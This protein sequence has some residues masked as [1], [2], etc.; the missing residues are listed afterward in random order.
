MKLSA[1]TALGVDISGG[2]INLALL[3]QSAKGIELVKSASRPAPDGAIENGC[4]ADSAALARAI[5]ELKDRNRMHAGR[6]A[7]SLSVSPVITS[8]LEIP[9]GS[10][11]NVGQFVRDELKSYVVLSGGRIAFDFC[12]IRSGQ[13]SESRLLAVAADDEDVTELVRTCIR[14]G[15]NVEAVEPPMLACVRALYADRIENRF[16]C[17]VLIGLVHDNDL[18]LCV[19]RR[20]TLELVRVEDISAEKAEPDELCRRLAKEINAIIRFYEVEEPDRDNK[21]EVTVFGDRVQLP[22]D[23]EEF[24]RSEISSSD[25]EVRSGADVFQDMVV[26]QKGRQERPSALAVSLAVGFFDT[27]ETGL[28]I[29]LVP[30]ESAEVRS[31]KRQLALT[32]AVVVLAIPLLAFLAGKGFGTLADKVHKGI[33]DKGQTK[34]SQDMVALIEEQKSLERQIELLSKRPAGLNA[35]LDSRQTVDWANILDEVKSRTPETVRITA[36]YTEAETEMSLEGL[37][38]SYEAARLFEK[39]LNESDCISTAFLSKAT[40]EDKV[41]GLVMYTIDCTVTAGKSES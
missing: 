13:G 2:Q 37:A 41:G 4:I 29:N 1:K 22:D 11:R 10:P 24:L 20:Q 14:S 34:V 17:S 16:D 3:R 25:L 36:L 32:T 5:R 40:R 9:E 19:F 28:K 31:V 23:A 12:R 30:P 7:V 33:D 6:A 15:L 18:T 21:W 8:I 35:I 39:K 38:L 27:R 26:K